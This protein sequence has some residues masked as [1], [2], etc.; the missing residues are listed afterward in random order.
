[1]NDQPKELF[2]VV[3]QIHTEPVLGT[4]IANMTRPYL[5]PEG[6]R[7]EVYNALS[8]RRNKV[9]IADKETLLSNGFDLCPE[10]F[11]EPLDVLSKKAA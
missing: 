1:M 8:N 4:F 10:D 2:A 11:N 7:S 3:L 5:V 9:V 6:R